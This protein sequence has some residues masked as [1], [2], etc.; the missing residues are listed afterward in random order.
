M[1][2][3]VAPLKKKVCGS[4]YNQPLVSSKF[5]MKENYAKSGED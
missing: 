4:I 1:Q 3:V 2:Y 5:F